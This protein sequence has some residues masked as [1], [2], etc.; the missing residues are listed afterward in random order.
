MTRYFVELAYD[1]TNYHGWQVQPNA[2]TVQQTLEESFTTLMKQEIALTGCGRTDTGVH[3]SSYTAHFDSIRNDIGQ[4]KDLTFRLNSILPK[5]IVI[6]TIRPVDESLHARFSAKYRHYTYTIRRTKPVFTRP[7]CYFYFGTLDTQMMNA[8]CEVLMEYTDFTSFS[9]LHTDVKTHDCQ[10]MEA[11]WK[12][13]ED[14]YDF[15]IRA[16]R[17]LRNMVRSIVGTM[18]DIGSGKMDL[19]SFRQVVEAKD[20]GKAGMSVPAKGLC[21]VEV[22]Y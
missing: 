17:F 2:V 16:D 9:K 5:D 3:A 18:L 8:A 13:N 11:A 14:G 10:I 6:Y 22:G 4:L 7:F 21:L 1:G 19:D 20:R 15:N 12:E